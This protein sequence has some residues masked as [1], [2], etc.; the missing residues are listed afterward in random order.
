MTYR[1]RVGFTFLILVGLYVMLFLPFWK[2]VILG[3]LFACACGPLERRLREHLH[4]SN[5]RPVAYAVLAI[6]TLIVGVVIAVLVVQI[7]S[8]LYQLF[9]NKEELS[10]LTQRLSGAHDAIWNWLESKNLVFSEQWQRQLDKIVGTTLISLRDILIERAQMFFA[11]TPVILLNMFIFVLAFSAFLLMGARA[12]VSAASTFG[13]EGDHAQQFHRFE[14]VCFVSLGSVILVGMMQASIVTIGA[15]I[16]GT[17]SYFLVFALTFIGSMIPI[18]GAGIVPVGF[19]LFNLIQGDTFS[20]V[21]FGIT[22]G[23]TGVADNVLKAWLFSKA[24]KTN[25]V[26]SMISLLG[27]VSLMGFAGLFIAPTVEQLVMAE[28]HRRGSDNTAIA[29]VPAR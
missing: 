12:F 25:P 20:S 18:T 5:R 26:V 16:C 7:Y 28:F 3:F 14:R 24:S 6:S 2:P 17:G 15:R 10:A 21:V 22:A 8:I 1:P 4:T 29:K 23:I 19:L 13:I 9:D 27:G 11:A